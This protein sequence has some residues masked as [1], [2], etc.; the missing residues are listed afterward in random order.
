MSIW[1][2]IGK[3]LAQMPTADARNVARQRL[4]VVTA[5]GLSCFIMIALQVVVLSTVDDTRARQIDA[6][7]SAVERGK[8]LDRNGRVLATS[9]PA[10]LLYADP[11]E[12][13]NPYEA[14]LKLSAI[15]PEMTEEGIFRKLTKKNRYA[16][17]SW[18]VSPATYAKVLKRGVVGVYGKKRITR[19]YPQKEEAA[20]VVGVVN[21]NNKGIAGIE[22]GMNE[23]LARGEDV[24]LSLDIAV[25]SI[26]REEIESQMTKFDAIGGA[27]VVLDVETGELIALVSLPQYDANNYTDAKP[28]A[29]FNRASKGTYELGSIFKI[30]NT[31]VAL[32][33]GRF[34]ITDKI[35]VVTPLQVGRFSIQDFHP[36]KKPLNIAEVMVV[37]S[38]IGSARMADEIGAELQQKYL[39]FL[40]LLSRLDLELP[41]VATPQIPDV[42]RQDSV[43][44]ISYGHGISVTPTHFAAAV[45]SIVGGGTKVY[46]SLIKGGK[47]KDFDEQ[48]V[49]PETAAA[50]RAIMHHSV[51]H[52]RGTG[53][54]ARAKGYVVGGKTGTSE[55]PKDGGYN[56]NLN[57]ASF[58][59]AFPSHAPR[60][61]VMVMVDEPKGQKFSYGYSTG[62]WVAAPAVQ[63]FITR[64]A[65][66][67]NV[68]PVD[69]KSPKIRQLLAVDLPQLDAEKTHASF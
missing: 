28:D 48:V 37:S 13:M 39:E 40:G 12:I 54:K 61:V 11:A 33:S 31:A 49:N 58:I 26:L 65:P 29:K 2:K 25:Q 3:R 59:A 9:L 21:K 23:K 16:E 38:N 43:M 44:T 18:R 60:Y 10:Y 30:I 24:H 52:R 19:F 34:R 68:T 62:G 41:E 15:L 14:T 57:I 7:T 53:K 5:L 46:P 36:E 50:I 35:D 20:H 1:H 69:E 67:L 51:N 4:Y 63:R 56:E 55:K 47:N 64:A 66:L 22:S 6:V 8:I 42:W 27:G 45:A 17:L 32:D